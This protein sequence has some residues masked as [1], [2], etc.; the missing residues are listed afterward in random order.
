MFASPGSLCHAPSITHGALVCRPAAEGRQ[1]C[2]LVCNRGYQ[3]SLPV[4]SFLCETESGQ[5]GGDNVPLGGACQS[6]TFDP[7]NNKFWFC[8]DPV[9]VDLSVVVFSLAA[10]ADGVVVSALAAA[11]LLLSDQLPAAAAVQPDDQQG[12]LLCSGEAHLAGN[13][14]T[15]RWRR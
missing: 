10:S 2:D 5:W 8:F 6:T 1:S 3:N 14:Q 12:A 7:V 13:P 15:T 4:S 11:V 9:G